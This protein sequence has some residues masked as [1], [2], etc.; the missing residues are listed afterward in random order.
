MM[1]VLQQE[2]NLSVIRFWNFLVTEFTQL[3]SRLEE[4]LIKDA[5]SSF[6][7]IYRR[8]SISDVIQTSLKREIGMFVLAMLDEV[9]FSVHDHY[10]AI[11]KLRQKNKTLR[12]YLENAIGTT[13]NPSAARPVTPLTKAS[14]RNQPTTSNFDA[15]AM[16][17]ASSAD[18]EASLNHSLLKGIEDM[19]SSIRRVND[20]ND[21]LETENNA[22]KKDLSNLREENAMLNSIIKIQHDRIAVDAKSGNEV[23][24]RLHLF[25]E[26][27]ISELKE[28]KNSIGLSSQADKSALTL[29]RK[30][31]SLKQVTRKNITQMKIVGTVKGIPRPLTGQGKDKAASMS[32]ASLDR[33]SASKVSSE[34]ASAPK[35]GSE[36]LKVSQIISEGVNVSKACSDRISVS[37]A[38]SDGVSVSKASSEGASVPRR[39]AERLTM[40]KASTDS[41][42][43]ITNRSQKL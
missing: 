14:S 3:K 40:S 38:S 26:D 10:S 13:A 15:T 33:I 18:S 42:R 19:R 16:V 22:L 6:E 20:E 43:I 31:N 24:D 28:M 35:A 34:E 2:R 9:M 7:R 41:N 5:Y 25:Q 4:D 21:R 37:K 36:R 12:S 27:I 11:R 23:M 30:P 32:K 29:N 1:A 17:A 8:T 39:S